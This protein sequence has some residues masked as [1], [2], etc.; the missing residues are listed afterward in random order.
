MD[1]VQTKPKILVVEDNET[2]RK[3]VKN[4]LS[5]AGYEVLEAEN[6]LRGLEIVRAEQPVLIM[7]D[8]YMPVMDG[9][10]MLA[11]LKKDEVLMKTPVVMVTNVQE[12]LENAVKAG[13]E[14][15]IL[16]SSL[17][18]TQIIDVFK[19]YVPLPGGSVLPTS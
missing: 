4:A 13:A 5:I 17:T 18:P 7:I 3:I 6:G 2:Y 12:E 10:T 15:A 11:E 16:K 9:M 14:E 19:K 1:Q 8:I